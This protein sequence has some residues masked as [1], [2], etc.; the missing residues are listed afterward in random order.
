MTSP[1]V[2]SHKEGAVIL[3]IGN[4]IFRNNLPH[5][6]IFN[7]ET[8]DEASKFRIEREQKLLTFIQKSLDNRQIT[9]ATAELALSTWNA[10]SHFVDGVLPVPD[11]SAMPEDGF[12][13]VWNK[14]KH[15]LEIEICQGETEIFYRN[16]DTNE[17]W[18]DTLDL[19]NDLDETILRKILLFT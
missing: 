14:D 7:V 16:R 5:A 9:R 13:F 19:S 17:V 15:H 18:G 12:I 2:M 6:K 8:S 4:V 3:P 1:P 10:I 11:A